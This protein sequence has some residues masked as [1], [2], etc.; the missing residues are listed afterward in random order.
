MVFWFPWYRK[1]VRIIRKTMGHMM[2]CSSNEDMCMCQNDENGQK[3][4]TYGKNVTKLY[5]S[6][7][8]GQSDVKKP[9]GAWK[10]IVC[11]HC[12]A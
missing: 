6:V 10:G 11:T 8:I 7:F 12:A 5:F 2:V 4:L 1:C 9:R 3:H